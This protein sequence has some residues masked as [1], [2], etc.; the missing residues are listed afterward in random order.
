MT[1]RW[2]ST[3]TAKV[4]ALV[5]LCLANV[6]VALGAIIGQPAWSLA[7]LVAVPVFLSSLLLWRMNVRESQAVDLVASFALSHVRCWPLNVALQMFLGGP[8]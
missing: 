4:A 6:S 3:R 7:G 2:I 1:G 5:A 8:L